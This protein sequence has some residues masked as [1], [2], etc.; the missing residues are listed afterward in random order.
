MYRQKP[1]DGL[2]FD[3]DQAFDNVHTIAAVQFYV[4]IV[5]GSGTCLSNDNS[6]LLSS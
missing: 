3:N 2:K 1:F 4:F 5:S 6:A